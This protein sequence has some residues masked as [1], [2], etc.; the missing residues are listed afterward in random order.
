MF[1]KRRPRIKA[2]AAQPA[3]PTA[4]TVVKVTT[5]QDGNGR[6][7]FS[8]PVI[9]QFDASGLVID[10]AQ[11]VS[12]IVITDQGALELQYPSFVAPGTAWV[13]DDSLGGIDLIFANGLPLQLPE[14]GTVVEE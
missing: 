7:Y 4:V 3:P 1:R 12:V 6:W 5:T 8:S 13:A 2:S 10:G 11:P 14:S 9:D